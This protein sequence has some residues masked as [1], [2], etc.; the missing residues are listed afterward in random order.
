MPAAHKKEKECVAQKGKASSGMPIPSHSPRSSWL[1]RDRTNR[2]VSP[3]PSRQR[4]RGGRPALLLTRQQPPVAKLEERARS[5]QATM[6]V[7]RRDDMRSGSGRNK[8]QEGALR[9]PTGVACAPWRS[10][11]PAA[12]GGHQIPPRHGGR[13]APP[14]HGGRRAP[15]SSKLPAPRGWSARARPLAGQCAVAESGPLEGIGRSLPV[16]ACRSVQHH[17]RTR[18]RR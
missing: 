14:R 8:L 13:R 17:P 6:Q 5:L 18:R 2:G 15:A 9:L 1:P 11:S 10:P 12:H 3:P 16:L 4:N 7:L